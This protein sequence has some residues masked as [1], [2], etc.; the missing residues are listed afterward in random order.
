PMLVTGSITVP[1]VN[2]PAGGTV[3]VQIHIRYAL[4]GS[5]GW[6]ASSPTDFVR[7]YQAKTQFTGGLAM[8]NP[9]VANF[10]E[11]GKKVTA[12]GGYTIDLNGITKGGL[13]IAVDALGTTC[14]TPS[15][16]ASQNVT[17][18]YFIPVSAGTASTVRICSSLG[19]Q[20]AQQTFSA[21]AQDEFRQIEFT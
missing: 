1:A 5:T 6:P 9:V 4:M 2:V 17:G 18:F 15:I 8:T 11:T 12:V 3:W 14:A 21:L 19:T 13:G 20:V 10:I 16:P 7:G